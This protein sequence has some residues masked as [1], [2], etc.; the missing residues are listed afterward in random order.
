MRTR[1]RILCYFLAAL[2]LVSLAPART[3]ASATVFFTAVNEQLLP[4]NDETMPFWS[5]GVLYI[6][7]TAVDS[8]DLG[9]HFSL[10]RDR[11]TAVVYK[12]RN[13]ITFDLTAGT[14]ETSSGASYSTGAVVRGD[15][16]F[17]PLD[18]VC[19]FL[20]LEYSYTRTAYGYLVRMRSETYA[21]SDER[22]LNAASS[23][24]SQRYAQYMRAHSSDGSD[25]SAPPGG[26]AQPAQTQEPTA[27]RTIFPVFDSTDAERSAQV[28]SLFSAGQAAF[29]FSP[30]ALGESGDLLRRLAS[31]GGVIALRIDASGGT[32][33]ALRRIEDANRALWN[34]ANVKTRLVRLDGASEETVSAVE[35]SGYRPLRFTLDYGGGYAAVARMTARI[36]SAADANHG[37]CCVY[38][39]TDVTALGI[40][41]SLLAGL[42]A[43]NC[44]SAR[45]NEVNAR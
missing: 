21:L 35:A 41:P 14:C 13:A 31:G 3:D 30:Q 40:L 38:L 19:R 37:S 16:V 7:S 17:L 2:M 39:G 45:L 34:A 6:P 12:M 42:T 18:L 25:P 28:L 5:G 20:G 26:S 27:A 43:G 8:T 29:L 10:S 9:T 44:T 15:V 36:F 23:L 33:D 22:F 1:R 32:E 24:M 4:L 11:A